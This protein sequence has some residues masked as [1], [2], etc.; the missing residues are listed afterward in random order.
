M[1]TISPVNSLKVVV[2]IA[3]PQNFGKSKPADFEVEFKKLPISEV[4]DILKAVESG[5][6][7]DDILMAEN[8]IGIKG[9]KD[10]EGKDLEYNTDLLASILEIEYVRGPLVKAFMTVQMG[11]EAARRKN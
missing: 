2:K 9:L 8:I 11:Q 3:V 5:D 6:T 10:P 4:R 7:T 1:F